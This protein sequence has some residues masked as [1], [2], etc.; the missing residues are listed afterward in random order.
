METGKSY[1]GAPGTMAQEIFDRPIA[2]E[3][4]FRPDGKRLSEFA[5]PK[6]LGNPVSF[7]S[8]SFGIFVWFPG[9]ASYLFYIFDMCHWYAPAR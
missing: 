5:V 1:V 2:A 3:K 4:G 6:T 9:A 8:F 7:G